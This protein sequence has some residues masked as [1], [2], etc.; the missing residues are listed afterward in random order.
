MDV[1]D[2]NIKIVLCNYSPIIQQKIKKMLQK[3]IYIMV[4]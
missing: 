1:W 2:L 3:L 4:N